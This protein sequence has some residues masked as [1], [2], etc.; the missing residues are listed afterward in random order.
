[1]WLDIFEL[2][3]SPVSEAAGPQIDP[4]NIPGPS[5]VGPSVDD[6]QPKTSP[7]GSEADITEPTPNQRDPTNSLPTEDAQSSWWTRGYN[8]IR[9]VLS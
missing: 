3:Q 5:P 9:N 6:P 1:M 8:F 2:R 4:P 7:G